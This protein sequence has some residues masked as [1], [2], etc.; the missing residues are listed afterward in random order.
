MLAHDDALRRP[1]REVQQAVVGSLAEVHELV[2]IDVAPDDVAAHDDHVALVVA[3]SCAGVRGAMAAAARLRESSFAEHELSLVVGRETK[4][5]LRASD[6]SAPLALVPIAQWVRDPGL[7]LALEVG[8]LDA[9]ERSS[10]GG[11]AQAADALLDRAMSR[12]LSR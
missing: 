11:L 7:A 10:R 6:V 3:A 12:A 8:D 4:R 2:V 5:S 9:V 1:S